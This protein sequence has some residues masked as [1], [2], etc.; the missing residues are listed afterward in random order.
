M[1]IESLMLFRHFSSCILK[2]FNKHAS[3]STIKLHPPF[4]I[5]IK[6]IFSPNFILMIITKKKYDILTLFLPYNSHVSEIIKT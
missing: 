2:L 4:K 1:L 5:T 3:N 6:I